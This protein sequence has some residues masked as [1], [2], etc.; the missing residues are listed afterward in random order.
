MIL[1][2]SLLF[3]KDY[4]QELGDHL[5]IAKGKVLI[6][7]AFLTE[8]A[9]SW[10]VQNIPNSCKVRIVSRWRKM[11]LLARASDIASCKIALSNNWSFGIDLNLHAKLI[12]IDEQLAFLGSANLTSNGVGLSQL[13][14]FE[15]GTKVQ[16]TQDD[17]DKLEKYLDGVRWVDEILLDKIEK[18]LVVGKELE[19]G[20][21]E[22]SQALNSD[23]SAPKE[24]LFVSELFQVGPKELLNTL[25]VSDPAHLSA[26][27]LLR[28]E[29]LE[30]DEN[31]LAASF[32]NTSVWV[33]V[34]GH[35]KNEGRSYG[36]LS[37]M[38]HRSL[39]VEGLVRRSEI[40]KY[41]S[42]IFE[43]LELLEVYNKVSISQ[44]ARTAV[45][46]IGPHS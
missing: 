43:W 45:V 38:L 34:M 23:L 18:E 25:D 44:Y 27:R 16:L 26:L 10:L 1:K 15:I 32:L 42:I 36:Y 20:H 31:D 2:S 37:K 7:S 9:M 6:L 39:V 46:K 14:N 5:N 12:G 11:D 22:W 30:L 19:G 41:L 21:Q 40:K 28:I 24:H 35:C 3:N 33:W 8:P 13:S 29:N 17:V 4:R